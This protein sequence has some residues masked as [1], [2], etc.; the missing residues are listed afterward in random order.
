MVSLSRKYIAYTLCTVLGAG[1]FPFVPG[2]FSS[3]LAV[4]S[5]YLLQPAF[6]VL[7]PGLVMAFLCGIIFTR[8]IE[9]NDGKDPKHIVIDELAGQWLTFL[10]IPHLSF[11]VIICGFVLFRFFD[12]LKPFGINSI[13][14]MKDGWGVM[15]DDILAGLYSNI[16]LQILI[17]MGIII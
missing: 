10:L 6:Y 16:L 1:Y 9:I 11:W 7:L 8:D 3:I 4:L 17:V 5:L 14:S 15:L 2:T 13:Q 12:I